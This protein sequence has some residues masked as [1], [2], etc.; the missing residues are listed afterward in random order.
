MIFYP[1]ATNL[2]YNYSWKYKYFIRIFSRKIYEFYKNKII[3]YLYNKLISLQRNIVFKT[4]NKLYLSWEDSKERIDVSDLRDV[5]PCFLK[6]PS[7][8]VNPS[9]KSSQHEESSWLW[10]GSLDYSDCLD[11]SMIVPYSKYIKS[12]IYFHLF[13]FWWWLYM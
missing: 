6:C 8:R 3:N 11:D 4:Y 13:C 7:G 10:Y 1:R 12:W 9:N 5:D 2:W